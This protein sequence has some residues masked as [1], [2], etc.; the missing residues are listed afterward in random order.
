MTTIQEGAEFWN[1]LAAHV[2]SSP[3]VLKIEFL[4]KTFR[5]FSQSFPNVK[6]Q[7]VLGFGS[8][9]IIIRT[10]RFDRKFKTEN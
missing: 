7:I 10:T 1:F 6:V 3:T 5:R 8:H 2:I 9:V 4:K